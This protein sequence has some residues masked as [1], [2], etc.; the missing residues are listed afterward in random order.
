M[1]NYRVEG[2]GPPLLLVHGFGI[3]FNIWRNLLPHLREHFTLVMVQLPGIGDSPAPLEDQPYIDSAVEG[4]EQVRRNLGYETLD[5]LGYSVGSRLVE[6]YVQCHPGHVQQAI[7]LCPIQLDSSHLLGLRLG[8]KLNDM[9]PAVGSWFLHGWRLKFLLFWLG[10]S[11]RQ[12]SLLSEWQA[13]MESLPVEI[14]KDNLRASLAVGQQPFRVP[15]P[16]A[17]IWGDHDTVSAVPQLPGAEDYIVH[18]SHAA[19]MLAA[20]DVAWIIHSILIGE[21]NE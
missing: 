15:V 8:F 19:P 6:A 9:S 5:I 11:L 3:S 7:F 17:Y 14:L 21:A 4:L 16:A 12:N 1:L 13:E 10:F 18:S 20:K 2:N